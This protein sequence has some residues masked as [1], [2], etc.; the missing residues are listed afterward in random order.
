MMVPYAVSA[1]MA[2]SNL[3]AAAAPCQVAIPETPLKADPLGESYALQYMSLSS[4]ESSSGSVFSEKIPV[5]ELQGHPSEV[6]LTTY[7]EDC[8]GRLVLDPKCVRV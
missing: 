8:A 1:S 2:T 3:L 5:V 6:D 4:G 7:H